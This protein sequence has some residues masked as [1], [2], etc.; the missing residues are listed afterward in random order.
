M[1]SL[2]QCE[3]SAAGLVYRGAVDEKNERTQIKIVEWKRPV[4]KTCLFDL[5]KNHSK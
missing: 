2:I 5:F 1:E 3:S 4:F